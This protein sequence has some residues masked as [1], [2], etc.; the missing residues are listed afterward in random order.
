MY[1]INSLSTLSRLLFVLRHTPTHTL[2]T[3]TRTHTHTHPETFKL[4]QW[5][6]FSFKKNTRSLFF[7][8]TECV[9]LFFCVAQIKKNK[10][11][12]FQS[13]DRRI[14]ILERARFVVRKCF[15]ICL[16]K[17]DLNCLNFPCAQNRVIFNVDFT[18]KQS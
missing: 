14:I 15:V 4:T 13:Y 11:P 7:S 3:N 5:S 2:K 17:S 8:A 1:V 12:A 18:S 6:V 9:T 10:S 16:N